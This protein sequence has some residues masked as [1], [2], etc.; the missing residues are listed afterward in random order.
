M[1]LLAFICAVTSVSAPGTFRCSDHTRVQL[2]AVRPVARG[3]VSAA[4]VAQTLRCQGF[5]SKGPGHLI[6]TCRFSSGEDVGCSLVRDGIVAEDL[7]KQRHY[8]LPTCDERAA[9]SGS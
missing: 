7:R 6:A 9:L 3:Q 4:L 1:F 8:E 2:A 5:D